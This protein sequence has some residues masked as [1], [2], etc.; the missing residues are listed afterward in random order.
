M[1][2]QN[3]IPFKAETRQLLDILIHSLYTEREV[4]LRELISNASD[5]ITRLNYEMLTNRDVHQ[6][7]QPLG[8]WIIPNAENHT[9]TIRDTGIGMNAAELEENLGTIAHSGARAFLQA[10]AQSGA[11]PSEMIGQFGVGFYAAFMVAESMRVV[12]RSYRPSD[13]PAEWFSTGEDT[14]TIQPAEKTDRGTEV[15][16]QLKEDAHEFT[17]EY[18]L[19]SIVRRH[20]DYIPYPIYIGDSQEQVNRL[21]A[22]WRQS[23][24]EVESQS[25]TDFFR[26]LTMESTP[27]LTHLHL[28]IDAPLQLYAVLFVPDSPE[29]SIFSSRRQDGLALYARK[30]LIQEYTLDLLPDYLRFLVGVVDSEDLPLN[31]SRE[32]IQS[33]RI[34]SQLRKLLTSKVLDHLK[35]L[36]QDQPEQYVTF[37]EKY[38][39]FIKEGLATDMENQAALQSLLR[40]HT[41]QKP[42]QWVSLS[43]Y[44]QSL[45]TDQKSIYYLLGDDPRSIQKSPH[46]EALRAGNLDVLFL[47]DPIDSFMLLRLENYHDFPLVN[48]AAGNLDLPKPS[49]PESNEQPSISEDQSGDL[50]RRISQQLGERVSAVRLTDRLVE[51]PARLVDE[52]GTLEPQMQRVYR[53]L[54][55]PY[56]VPK[57]VLEINPRHPI[58]KKLHHLPAG[59]PLEESVIEQIYENA[60]LIEG[61]HPDP[62]NMIARI[63]RLMEAA[64]PPGEN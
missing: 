19:R 28:N 8:I 11:K 42:D 48:I 46:L 23:P 39:R 43:E 61:L 16:I 58:L 32:S 55:K 56:E 40:F 2:P 5:A 15:I 54:D 9:L 59:H 25:Y 60:L 14:F 22:L 7:D 34:I 36:A 24:R 26:Q 10:A 62:A 64:L 29:R 50:I 44:V 33:N 13:A 38:G 4:F 63:Q 47:T 45:Q 57:K 35:T 1:N 49:S 21:T 17:Q 53:L 51:S 27:P 20:S 30:V 12:S 37:W 31:V 18:R 41:L 52:E 3:P 6:P